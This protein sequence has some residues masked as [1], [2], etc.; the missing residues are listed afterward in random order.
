LTV[1]EGA[2]GALEIVHKG[3]SYTITRIHD[4]YTRVFELQHC[5]LP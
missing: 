2:I 4:A 1:D 5:M 3:L